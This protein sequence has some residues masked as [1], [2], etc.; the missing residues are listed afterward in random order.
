MSYGRVDSKAFAQKLQAH[1]ADQ[2]FKV[3]FDFNDIPLGVD[4]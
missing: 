2:S 3:W 4:Y 1:L